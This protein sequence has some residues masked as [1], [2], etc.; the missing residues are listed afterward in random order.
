MAYIRIIGIVLML[1]SA[2]V[3]SAGCG[4]TAS[5]EP[6]ASRG[7]QPAAPQQDRPADVVKDALLRQPAT[8][9]LMTIVVEVDPADRARVSP[10]VAKVTAPGQVVN[11][12]VYASFASANGTS[13]DDGIFGTVYGALKSSTGGM[14]GNLTFTPAPVVSKAGFQAGTVQDLDS[15]GDRDVGGTNAQSAAEWICL[16][17]GPNTLAAPTSGNRLLIGTATFTATDAPSG[18]TTTVAWMYRNK[19]GLGNLLNA[20]KVDNVNHTLAGNDPRLGVVGVQI[21]R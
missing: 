16:M 14:L 8:P 13:T 21:L 5:P 17:S 4:K 15:D 10:G 11:L 12:N 1:G 18:A 2:L 19:T 20:I 6:A 3:L 9:A 7:V